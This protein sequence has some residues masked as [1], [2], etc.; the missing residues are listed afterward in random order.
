MTNYLSGLMSSLIN[1][2]ETLV[3]N[4]I[5]SVISDQN[6]PEIN[7][8]QNQVD[9]R[10]AC[11]QNPQ[12]PVLQNEIDTQVPVVQNKTEPEVDSV[13]KKIEPDVNTVEKKIEPEVNSVQKKVDTQVP[14]IQKK[15]EPEVDGN[16]NRIVP[17]A[18]RQ[19]LSRSTLVPQAPSTNDSFKDSRDWIKMTISMKR[20]SGSQTWGFS[21]IHPPNCPI[22]IS[23]VVN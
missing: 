11:V 14:V 1:M 10:S 18:R 2:A 13:E 6:K 21:L 3:Q 9:T 23:K 5:D 20:S 17:E 12:V 7:P 22:I 8:V 16:Q 19:S 15:M 4:A